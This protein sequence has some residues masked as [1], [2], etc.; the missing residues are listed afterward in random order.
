M[1]ETRFAVTMKLQAGATGR[2]AALRSL[3]ASAFCGGLASL[4]G[5]GDPEEADAKRRQRRRAKRQRRH[6]KCTQR[7]S[8]GRG[9]RRK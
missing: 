3:A 5:A 9:H 8:S 7:R 4:S 6:S 2:R 1:A